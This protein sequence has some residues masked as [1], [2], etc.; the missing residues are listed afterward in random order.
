M[1]ASSHEPVDYTNWARS[2]GEGD[3]EEPNGGE[4]ENCV[5]KTVTYIVQY[6]T[7][8]YSTVQCSTVHYITV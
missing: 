6:S 8:Q 3:M 2:S 5:Y 1:W 7:V 4:A